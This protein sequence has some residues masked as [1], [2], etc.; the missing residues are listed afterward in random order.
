MFDLQLVSLLVKPKGN[1]LY[2]AVPCLAAGKFGYSL[3]I[4]SVCWWFVLQ[5]AVYF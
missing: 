5:L 2:N 3:Q 1:L 4:I